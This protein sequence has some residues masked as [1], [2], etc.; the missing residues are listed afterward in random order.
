MVGGLIGLQPVIRQHIFEGVVV[1]TDIM[2][3]ERASACNM[4]P[5]RQRKG[6]KVS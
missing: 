5:L 6:R 3:L 2:V 1:T 4:T